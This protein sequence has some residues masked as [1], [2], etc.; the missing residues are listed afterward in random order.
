[1][2]PQQGKR[3][4]ITTERI[5]VLLIMSGIY[6]LLPFIYITRYDYP[7]ADDYGFAIFFSQHGLLHMIKQ[8]YLGWGGRYLLPVLYRLNPTVAH[9]L[10]GYRLSAA[11]V[12]LLFAGVV[13]LTMRSLFKEYLSRRQAWGLSALFIGLYFAK[14]PSTAEAFYWYSSYSIY[15]LPNIFFLLLLAALVRLHREPP[16]PRHHWPGVHCCASSS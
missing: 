12:I 4:L 15:Q 2:P 14:T 6:V 5:N 8:Q 9:S 13:A 10:A 3:K 16:R 1:M 7:S 11:G